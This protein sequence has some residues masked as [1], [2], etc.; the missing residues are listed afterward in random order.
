MIIMRGIKR[1]AFIDALKGAL[2]MFVLFH[3]VLCLTLRIEHP[4]I[5]E[6]FNL[7]AMPTFFFA[8]GYLFIDRQIDCLQDVCNHLI[9]IFQRLLLPTISCTLI[10]LLIH[11]YISP[12]AYCWTI[13]DIFT[14]ANW[15]GYWFTPTLFV[16]SFVTIVIRFISCRVLFIRLNLL[17]LLISP[18]VAHFV[19]RELGPISNIFCIRKM[20]EYFP[21]YSLGLLVSNYR[22][23]LSDYVSKKY[24]W[25]VILSVCFIYLVYTNQYHIDNYIL[26]SYVRLIFAFLIFSCFQKSSKYWDSDSTFSKSVQYI[27]Q[28]S[29]GLYLLHYFFLPRNVHLHLSSIENNIFFQFVI[30]M[31]GGIILILLVLGLIKFLHCS[32]I[33]SIAFLGDSTCNY[34]AL[35]SKK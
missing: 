19:W 8:S 7:T 15:Q 10:Y 25:F 2:I 13:F 9:K 5:Y 12:S 32:R 31:S 23:F 24:F 11:N 27:G 21:F 6:I 28:S 33:T 16:I 26:F 35:I 22:G 14:D 4:Y 3:H 1:L 18:F 17:I 30:G 29:L 34:N 20:M